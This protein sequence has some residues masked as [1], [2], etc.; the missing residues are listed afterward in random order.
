M[1]E[2][3]FIGEV[4]EKYKLLVNTTYQSL[5]AAIELVKPG[6]LYRNLGEAI[7]KVVHKHGFQVV[8][9]YCGH[10]IGEYVFFLYL[11]AG[12]G[13]QFTDL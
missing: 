7:S 8:R 5:M 11:M 1:N 4:D 6:A 13:S 9:S 2:T 10:G 3:W 12:L